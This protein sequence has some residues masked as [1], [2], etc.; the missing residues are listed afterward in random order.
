MT[1]FLYARPSVMEGVG[2]NIDFYGSMSSY[3][4]SDNE[5]EADIIAIASDW[6]AI[7]MDLYKA[8]YKTVCQI[9]QKKTVA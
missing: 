8:C 4:Y 5:A 2:R 1:D 9:D 7:Y 3:N 6:M